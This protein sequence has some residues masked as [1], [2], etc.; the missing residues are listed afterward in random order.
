MIAGPYRTGQTAVEG[1]DAAEAGGVGSRN[2]RRINGL[3]ER[4]EICEGVR[5]SAIGAPKEI[6]RV[7]DADDRIKR[8][9]AVIRA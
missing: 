4:G 9:I 8:V 5:D 3:T 6:S 1:V 2:R 7:E